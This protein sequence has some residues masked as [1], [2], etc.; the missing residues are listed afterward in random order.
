[1]GGGGGSGGLPYKL[2]SVEFQKLGPMTEV[3]T[4][5]V[6]DKELKVS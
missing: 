5:W 3:A 6:A 2:Y 4:S 1:M